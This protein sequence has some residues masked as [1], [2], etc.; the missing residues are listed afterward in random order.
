MR[1]LG[2]RFKN[3]NSLVGEWGI[4]LTHPAFASNG[5]FAITGP[6]GAGKTTILD[7]VCLALYGATPRLKKVTKSGN[8]IM[9]RQTG[10]CYAEVTFET[11]AGR[12]RCHWSQHR[13]R[14]KP[15]GE[16]QAP[17][18]EIADADSGEIFEAN[19]RGVADKIEAATG[20]DF[21]RFTRSMLLAQG[22]FAAF[23]QAA[24]DERAPILEQITG[25][26][27]YSQISISAHER[28]SNERKK[29]ELLQAELA[30]VRLLSSEDEQRLSSE[31]KQKEQQDAE[32]NQQLKQK[33]LAIVWLDGIE[34]LEEELK[35]V[36]QQKQDLQTR[37]E[38]F[39][40]DQKK[41]GRSIQALE[42]E[43]EYA[44]LVLLRSEQETNRRNRGE[45]VKDVPACESVAKQAEEAVK[46]AGRQLETRK[47]EQRKV[48]L[49]ILKVRELDLK[50]REKDAPI[51]IAGNT[52]SE[53]EK[54]LEVLRTRQRK[55]CADLDSKR[56][57]H[58]GLQKRL[59]ETKVDEGL[60][61]HLTGI[62]RRFDVLQT[63]HAQYNGKL[64]EISKAEG[65]V[66]EA[67]RLW[68][69]QVENQEAQER[70]LLN[71]R[72][73]LSQKQLELGRILEDQELSEWRNSLLSLTTQK[74]SLA[75]VGE[76][77]R[78]LA[79]SRHALDELDKRYK[80]LTAKKSA[81]TEQLQSQTEKQADLEK[82]IDLLETQLSLL[83]KI[84]DFKEARHQLQ[85]GE[86]CPLCGA[87]EHPFAE[88]N[89]PVPDE[90]KQRLGKVKADLKAARNA[91]AGSTVKQ[92]ETSKDLDQVSFSQKEHAE[93]VAASETL[94]SQ[95]CSDLPLNAADPYLGEKL[96][97]LQNE[98]GA[99]LDHATNVVRDA[100]GVEK[101]VAEL[102][103]RLEKTKDAVAEGA[104]ET[105]TALYK[106]DTAGQLLERLKREAE[107]FQ[108]QRG[109]SLNILQ[110]DVSG[111]GVEIASLD[112]L[113][114]IQDQLTTR[115]DQWVSHRKEKA[116]LDQKIAALDIQTR[117]QAEE[118]Q[119]S[120]DE[121]RKQRKLLDDLLREQES[122]SQ[123]R[124]EA[125]GDKNPDEE[126]LRLS[127]TIDT[128]YKDLEDARQKQNAAV[129]ELGRLKSRIE[130]MDKSLAARASQLRSAED[131]FL[132]RLDGLE[133]ANEDIFKAA[134]LPE[135]E[136]KTLAQQAQKI[137]NEQTELTSKERDTT[138]LL[139][140]QR[141]KSVTDQPRDKLSDALASLIASQKE[142]QQ[143]I[144]GNRQKLK[145]N[146][147]L[148]Q[149][150]QARAQDIDAQ[151]R[152]CS[153]WDLLHELI[154]SSDGKKYRNFAQGLTFEMM[155][156]YANRQLRKMTDRYL[157]IRDSA[158]PLELN[159][160][161]SYQAGEVR[162]TKNLSGGE[163]FIVSLSLALG[164]SHMASKNVRVDSLFLDEGFG[165]LDEEALDTALETLAGLQ[166]DGKL[167]GVISHVPA[168]KERI[169]TQIQVVSQTRGTSVISGPGCGKA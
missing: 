53:Q 5:I 39:A 152:E 29:L 122:L 8:E 129:Q 9:S 80:A 110:Q 103:K 108:S 94:I 91:V 22:G 161:D 71:N 117:H 74:S 7:A 78:S 90:T 2:I 92:M 101:E 64:A 44:A 35:Q 38:A 136:R 67:N 138:K 89:I 124:R 151:K 165:T 19:I 102:R 14:R 105:Q 125:F 75:K 155:V 145:D 141:Q 63:L 147:D 66:T 76:A 52:I 43:G 100:E 154:G 116:E 126:E 85:D 56:K 12:Y 13:A 158:Q 88:G 164:L 28:R 49:I 51:K 132:V 121:I 57:T 10:E 72:G 61:E 113:D 146:E 59:D 20:M 131:A 142:L 42:L 37:Q 60:I 160:I 58:G 118:I 62:L 97:R 111:Y 148:K 106:K 107:D 11:R 54:S 153:R 163:S 104:R 112:N 41:L 84:E 32:L 31:L 34:R 26:E 24:P 169:S 4:D 70:N 168:L 144:G 16:L 156:G 167:I 25:T 115:R 130:E 150:Q 134:R 149:K 114:Q 48:A 166:Q 77:A 137:A 162:S 127:T 30:G 81:L 6:T 46:I 23:L 79:K 86:P 68:K 69:E 47:T 139:E 95:T 140:T 40:I 18:H 128:A 15:D 33:N 82:E 120:G 83:K 36:E 45:S 96:E 157:L 143:Q 159:V 135:D 93:K 99:K 50:I 98:N 55:D 133:F 109:Q 73:I 3:L 65:Q 1:I 123:E 17:K 21:D 119:K 27:I 87:K